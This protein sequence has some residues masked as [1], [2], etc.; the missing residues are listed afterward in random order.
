MMLLDLLE[1]AGGLWGKRRIFAGEYFE[2][3]MDKRK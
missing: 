1:P 2:K 3:G